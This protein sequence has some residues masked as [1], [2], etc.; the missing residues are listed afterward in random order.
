MRL[1]SAHQPTSTDPASAIA[2]PHQTSFDFTQRIIAMDAQ[3]LARTVV[4]FGCLLIGACANQNSI[5]RVTDTEAGKTETILIDAKQRPITV[6]T[7]KD[8]QKTCLARSADALSQA[9]ASG[10][11]KITEGSASG[12]AGFADNET[13]TS[14]A[15]RT[16]VTE[17]QQEFLYY[18]C[19]LNSNGVLPDGDVADNL[20]HFQNT[21]LAMVAIDDL[22][23][24]AKAKAGAADPQKTPPAADPKADAVKKA[25]TDAD[26]AKKAVAT[27]ATKVDT[28][29]KAVKAVKTVSGLKTP[30]DNLTAAL[31]AYDT[32][33][34]TYSTLL[35]K[36]SAAIKADA[37]DEAK[38]PDDVT[39]GTSDATDAAKDVKAEYQK[40]TSAVTAVAKVTD[41]S[42]LD[43]A[44][45]DLTKA[46]SDYTASVKQYE[47]A[48]A[49]LQ[50]SL[51]AWNSATA[52]EKK[53]STKSA[54]TGQGT[55]DS[56]ASVAVAQ[57]VTTIVQTIVW[58]S[59]IGEKCQAAIF[60]NFG[61]TDSSV[62]D[63]CLKHLQDADTYRFLALQTGAV[64][65][66]VPTE[67]LSE[68]MLQLKSLLQLKDT[69]QQRQ[70]MH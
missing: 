63:F 29:A 25:Q 47:D 58:Q 36:L 6:N 61:T 69:L 38:E 65:P 3:I 62:R 17:A 30:T 4:F 5:F 28:E 41:T 68:Q 67:P 1:K 23:S 66:G 19:Q 9:A 11:L 43:T 49:G 13:V 16:Q 7:N 15:F 53:K 27:A 12:E 10:N 35:G 70:Q 60:T 40:A 45:T 20:K 42:K 52:D 8:K 31:K 55:T 46:L 51:T 54:Q 39:S 56:S 21:M 33:Q 2:R 32:K 44:Q 64:K 57:A 34:K 59:F 50:K 22:A 14:I 24:S 48:E 26:A 18:L 37:G